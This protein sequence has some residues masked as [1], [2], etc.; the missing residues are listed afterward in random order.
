MGTL[1]VTILIGEASVEDS[2][3]G[4][5]SVSI[6]CSLTGEASVED[7]SMGTESVSILCTLTGEASVED[8]SMGSVVV[9]VLGVSV[10]GSGVSVFGSGWGVSIFGRGWGSWTSGLTS[11]CAMALSLPAAT[12]IEA[13]RTPPPAPRRATAFTAGSGSLD[14]LPPMSGSSPLGEPSPLGVRSFG[15]EHANP[16][17]SRESRVCPAFTMI[18]SYCRRCEKLARMNSSESKSLRDTRRAQGMSS[19]EHPGGGKVT[20]FFAASSW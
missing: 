15:D 14:P 13:P 8:S 9:S 5:E 20:F 12:L 6:L 10:F 1:T 2:S 18:M 19:F 7:S 16:S 3:M 4:T 17:D 11:G